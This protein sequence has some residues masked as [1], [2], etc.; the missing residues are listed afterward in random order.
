M[1]LALSSPSHR[2]A[3]MEPASDSEDELAG[4]FFGEK[5]DD[6]EVIYKMAVQEKLK[7]ELDQHHPHMNED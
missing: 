3:N 5:R 4:I 1:T 7:G 2:Y 6:V